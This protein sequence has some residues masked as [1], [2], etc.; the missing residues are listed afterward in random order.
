ML[1][2]RRLERYV[3]EHDTPKSA[4]VFAIGRTNMASSMV[5]LYAELGYQNTEIRDPS[6]PERMYFAAELKRN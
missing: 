6:Y 2:K 1:I 4:I 5:P 3:A